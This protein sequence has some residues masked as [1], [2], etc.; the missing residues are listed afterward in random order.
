MES[1]ASIAGELNGIPDQTCS[2]FLAPGIE[3]DGEDTEINSLNRKSARAILIPLRV[4]IK[5]SLTLYIVSW[6]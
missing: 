2:R 3:L 5:G 6:D 4:I 1:L